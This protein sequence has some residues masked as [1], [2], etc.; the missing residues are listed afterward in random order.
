M[1][2]WIARKQEYVG[3]RLKTIHQSILQDNLHASQAG[4]L[5]LVPGRRPDRSARF[6]TGNP[7]FEPVPL[8]SGC[9]VIHSLKVIEM[10]ATRITTSTCAWGC[11]WPQAPGNQGSRVSE[12]EVGL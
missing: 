6:G 2:V 8:F 9:G 12:M 7:Q 3:K 11:L 5:Y 1:G 4:R 10:Q